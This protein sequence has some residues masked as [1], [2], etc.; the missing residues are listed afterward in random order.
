MLA[1]L[2]KNGYANLSTHAFENAGWLSWVLWVKVMTSSALISR[3]AGTGWGASAL[4]LR[5]ST[6]ALVYAPAQCCAPVW[7]RST[8]TRLVDVGLN[9]P[10]ITASPSH[11]ASL[12]P[13]LHPPV[14]PR[15]S[16]PSSLPVFLPFL[17]PLLPS[18]SL[19]SLTLTLFITLAPSLSLPLPPS[20][21][22]PP[23]HCSLVKY[24]YIY[25]KTLQFHSSNSITMQT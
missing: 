7:C 12:S 9:T 6:T 1:T 25:N 3:L 15:S 22:P 19:F 17:S 24:Y 18:L 4:T 2:S 5:T 16:R 11:S 10:L 20:L 21:P 13:V 8:H 14:F 23:L